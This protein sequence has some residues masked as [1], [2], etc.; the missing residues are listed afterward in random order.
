[1]AISGDEQ[2]PEDIVPGL[3]NVQLPS[4]ANVVNLVP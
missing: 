3:L 1:M 4:L 2:L